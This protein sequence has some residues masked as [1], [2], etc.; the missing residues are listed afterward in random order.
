M[1]FTVLSKFKN[2]HFVRRIEEESLKIGIKVEFVNPLE[3]TIF[4]ND[5]KLDQSSIINSDLYILRT[6]SF[7]E[8]REYIHLAA[9]VITNKK[10]PLINPLSAVEVTG[11]KL[12][13]AITLE[14]V[15]IPVLP[16]VAVRKSDHLEEAVNS[17]GGFPVFLKTFRGT[18]GIGVIYCPCKETLRAAAQ[19]MWAYYSNVFV[20][21]FARD[22][23]GETLRVLVCLGKVIGAVKNRAENPNLVRSN[24]SGGGE[25][26]AVDISDEISTMSIDTCRTLGLYLGGVDLVKDEGRWKVLEVNSSPGIK[27]F[28]KSTGINAAGVIVERL[29]ENFSQ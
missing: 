16:A 3:T 27:G 13:T 14:K 1:K 15:G 19:T 25:V 23:G 10:R 17:V 29:V 5:V 4:L 21:K 18:R 12:K 26:S 8:D 7:R 11:N 9:E 24:F 20:E 28:E 6:P 22:S 2:S